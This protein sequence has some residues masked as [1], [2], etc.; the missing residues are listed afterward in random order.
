MTAEVVNTAKNGRAQNL[1]ESTIK[2]IT[3]EIFGGLKT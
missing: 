3:E 1:A 2:H